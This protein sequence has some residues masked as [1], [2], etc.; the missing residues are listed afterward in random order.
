LEDKVVDIGCGLNYSVVVNVD[1]EVL[2]FGALREA[3]LPASKD[4]VN[5]PVSISEAIKDYKVESVSCGM[6][7][8]LIFGKREE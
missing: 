7:H 6:K 8:V 1:G 3:G 5:T 2:G 4:R